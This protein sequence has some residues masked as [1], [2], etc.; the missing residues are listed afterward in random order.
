MNVKLRFEEEYACSR[1]KKDVEIELTG[2][3]RIVDA[4]VEVIRKMMKS[5]KDWREV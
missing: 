2:N 1:N 4:L 5:F 3:P